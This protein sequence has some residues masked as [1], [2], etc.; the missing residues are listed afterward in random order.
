VEKKSPVPQIHGSFFFVRGDERFWSA[1][2]E[3]LQA[4]FTSYQKRDVCSPEDGPFGGICRDS[5][6]KFL[7]DGWLGAAVAISIF[8]IY[9]FILI[10]IYNYS[11]I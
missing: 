1:T 7:E 8:Y 11:I 2:F 9:I 5:A 10:Y 6:A 3:D 4:L